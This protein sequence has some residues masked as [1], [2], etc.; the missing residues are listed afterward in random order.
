MN[1]NNI[2]WVFSFDNRRC[3]PRQA[4]YCTRL[5]LVRYRCYQPQTIQYYINIELQLCLLYFQGYIDRSL[6][7]DGQGKI[8]SSEFVLIYFT[9]SLLD[10]SSIFLIFSPRKTRLWQIK[11]YELCLLSHYICYC[12]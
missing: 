1:N 7:T 12:K 11:A 9:N 6:L 2:G 5:R 3:R 10:L 4:K 8:T